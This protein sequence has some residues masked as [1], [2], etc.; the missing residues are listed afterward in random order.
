MRVARILAGAAA[1][2]GFANVLGVVAL[3]EAPPSPVPAASDLPI[4]GRTRATTPFCV[5]VRDNVAPAVLGLMTVDELLGVSRGDYRRMAGD[6]DLAQNFGRIRLGKTVLAMA[7]DL[8]VVRGLLN[9]QRRFP[10]TAVTDDDRLALRLRSQLQAVAD[11]QEAALDMVNGVLETDLMSQMMSGIPRAPQYGGS[12]HFYHAVADA[13]GEQQA[14]VA[15][16]EAELA[17]TVVAAAS[18]CG[19][20]P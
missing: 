6:S 17:P 10:R 3:A 15:K 1:F 19:V 13:L 16:A 20:M 18:E 4:I 7:R 9:D 2:A 11:R 12:R 8:A 14:N 5:T